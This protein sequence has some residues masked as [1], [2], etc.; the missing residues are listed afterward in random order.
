MGK[1]VF[2]A[3]L[4]SAYDDAPEERY[5]FPRQYLARIQ[6]T[7]GD[8]I[9]YYESRRDGGRQVYFGTA[10]VV[11][12]GP[13][14]RQDGS[15]YAVIS[16]YLEFEQSVP[17]KGVGGYFQTSLLNP[18]GKINPGRA[19]N[20]VQPITEDEYQAILQAGFSQPLVLDASDATPILTAGLS[21]DV[22]EF[23]SRPIV[24]TI[25]NRPFRDRAF[26][27]AVK[28]AYDGTCAMTGLK[29]IN[30]GGRTEAE[31][32]HIKPVAH[33]GPDSVRNGIALCGTVHWMFDRGLISLTDDYKIIKANVGLPAAVD[34]LL[35]PNMELLVPE[36]LHLRPHSSFLSYHRSQIFKG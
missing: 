26:A 35:V 27:E 15:Y 8:W 28:R 13:D 30:G 29:I 24:Q 23:E 21:E 6:A 16:D 4:N 7:V 2:I 19:Q 31:A 12:I 5:H 33:S 9:I 10:R 14:P 32:A 36:Q 25:M 22:A 34:R 17:F 11:D 3:K 1:A 20:A 18:D